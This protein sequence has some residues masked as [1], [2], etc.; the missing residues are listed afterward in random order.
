M[1]PVYHE[2][3][4]K[5]KVGSVGAHFEGGGWLIGRRPVEGS[6]MLH[7]ICA[8]SELRCAV[9]AMGK[10]VEVRAKQ[11][12]AATSVRVT[13]FVESKSSVSSRR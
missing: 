9:M 11:A 5:A 8:S 7:S 6:R 10:V 3:D 2:T 1:M 12:R 4:T 13:V